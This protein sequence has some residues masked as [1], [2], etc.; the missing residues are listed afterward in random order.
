MT[1][2]K[3]GLSGPLRAGLAVPIEEQEDGD[4]SI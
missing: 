3:L 1:T 2:R 4:A